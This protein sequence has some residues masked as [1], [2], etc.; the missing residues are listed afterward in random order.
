MK[1]NLLIL[2]FLLFGIIAAHASFCEEFSVTKW[3]PFSGVSAMTLNNNILSFSST[4]FS[5][6]LIFKCKNNALL[7]A[8]KFKILEIRIKSPK[9]YATGKLLFRRISDVKFNES[10]Y[11][12]FQTGPAGVYHTCLVDCSKNPFWTGLIVRLGLTPVDSKGPVEMESVKFLEPDL[13]LRSG[14]ML[15]EFMRFEPIT[16]ITMNTIR[17]KTINDIPINVCLFFAALIFALIIFMI[18]FKQLR[19]DGPASFYF[20]LQNSFREILIVSLV[21]FAALEARQM[22]DYGRQFALDRSD[23]FGKSL[24]EKRSR[25]TY[26]NM[27][28][29]FQFVKKNLPENATASILFDYDLPWAIARYYLYPIR[30]VKGKADYILVLFKPPKNTKGYKLL[31]K[32]SNDQMI[33]V[34]GNLNGGR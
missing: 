22:V 32:L 1:K 10:C 24:D 8:D 13:L 28:E 14:A 31:A 21:L 19:F 23:L 7:D 16:G 2:S 5:P 4:S 18:N 15:Q 29:Y 3:E 20:S 11:V 17:G 25:I 9:S 34:K 33:L 30:I 27:Y 12:E 26:D 6:I